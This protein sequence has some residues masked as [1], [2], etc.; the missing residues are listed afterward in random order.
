MTWTKLSD[1]F[2][3][4][5]DDA[6]LSPEAAI[7]HVAALCYSMRL[8]TDGRLR[9][10]QAQRLYT[11]TDPE[12][13]I[14]DLIDAGYWTETD[15]GYE[16]V[17][18]LEDQR[19]AEAVRREQVLKKERQ[20][21]WLDKKRN[22]ETN[23]H[24]SRDASQDA[25]RDGAPAQPSPAQKKGAEDGLREKGSAPGGASL[26]LAHQ[27]K[28]Q[29]TTPRPSI[30]ALTGYMNQKTTTT[31]PAGGA[32]WPRYLSES[33]SGPLP[34]TKDE[35]RPGWV[36]IYTVL[37]DP[38]TGYL[39]DSVTSPIYKTLKSEFPNVDVVETDYSF[40]IQVEASEADYWLD[41]VMDAVSSEQIRSTVQKV[42]IPHGTPEWEIR[43]SK[44]RR[45]LNGADSADGNCEFT[46]STKAAITQI[47]GAPPVL[48]EGQS[49]IIVAPSSVPELEGDAGQQQRQ[50]F[51]EIANAIW[52]VISEHL[53]TTD[54]PAV[55]AAGI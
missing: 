33:K 27:R 51:G 17:N 38:P 36:E 10:K 30:E 54:T 25:S 14:Q 1:S 46:I 42:L 11:L 55:F 53:T 4:E 3:D 45:D 41:R 26:L 15:G 39:P 48:I 34:T 44:A 50:I 19:S 20:A 6:N 21:R 23:G 29:P 31:T 16:I 22:P 2:T 13:A 43:K 47:N 37:L 12:Q 24:R 7:L 40:S 49:V 5:L 8:L 32:Q 18:F 9:K 52:K 35:H 28:K